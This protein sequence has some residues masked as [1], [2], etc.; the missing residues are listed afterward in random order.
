MATLKSLKTWMWLTK[1]VWSADWV[2][3]VFNYKWKL[4]MYFS[5]DMHVYFRWHNSCMTCTSLGTLVQMLVNGMACFGPLGTNWALFHPSSNCLMLSCQE[6][7]RNI[8]STLLTLFYKEKG[9]S[10]LALFWC[11]HHTWKVRLLLKCENSFGNFTVSAVGH[12]VI[13][14]A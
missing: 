6:P 3:L 9:V 8:L 11:L 4:K 2:C 7:L 10:F 1:P 14:T 12:D 13:E 5:N